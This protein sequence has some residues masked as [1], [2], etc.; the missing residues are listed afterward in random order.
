[1]YSFVLVSVFLFIGGFA[2]QLVSVMIPLGSKSIMWP[3]VTGTPIE[4]LWFSSPTSIL[5]Q[6]EGP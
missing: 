2:Q 3:S 6:L 1:M 5:A 4:R